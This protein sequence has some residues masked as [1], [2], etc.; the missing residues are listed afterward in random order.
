M[1]SAPACRGG[2]RATSCRYLFLLLDPSF[3]IM[4]QRVAEIILLCE[5]LPQEPDPAASEEEGD[6]Q[7]ESP[8]EQDVNA[9]KHPSG[10]PCGETGTQLLVDPCHGVAETEEDLRIPMPVERDPTSYD[11]RE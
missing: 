3:K 7:R 5:F 2:R 8:E 11:G 9:E 4:R 1:P 6:D 10:S